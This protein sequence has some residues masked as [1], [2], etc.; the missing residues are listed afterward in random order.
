MQTIREQN[1]PQ[2]PQLAIRQGIEKVNEEFSNTARL[3]DYPDG[4]TVIMAAIHD[5]RVIVA[6]VGDSRAIIVG[7]YKSQK[8][9]EMSKDH[10][11]NRDDE[12]RRIKKLGGEV[13]YHGRW[14]VNGILAVSRA[15]GDV[16]LQVHIIICI[17]AR[18]L[19]KW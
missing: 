14:R 17:Y 18:S 15:V 16:K 7:N 6:N 10:K 9:K 12:L 2:D 13:I 19:S 1:F 11:P 5:Q 3:R 4:T 8:F